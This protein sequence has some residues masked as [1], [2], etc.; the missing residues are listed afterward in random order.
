MNGAMTVRKS[1]N[2]V[3]GRLNQYAKKLAK[4]TKLAAVDAAEF[5]RDEAKKICPVDT[6]ALRDSIIS[7]DNQRDGFDC[8]AIVGVGQKD[9]GFLFTTKG[10]RPVIKYPGDYAWMV[11]FGIS[12]TGAPL[13]FQSGKEARFLEK[14]SMRLSEIR[15][16]Y[17]RKLNE[18]VGFGG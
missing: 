10:G 18:G 6:G 11:H 1:S 2:D 13:A 9:I 8:V 7:F 3:A 17:N 12:R 4:R 5:I 14:T 15:Q 16:V